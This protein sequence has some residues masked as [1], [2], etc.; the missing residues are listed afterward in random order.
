[1][2]W[3]MSVSKCAIVIHHGT[4]RT[5]VSRQIGAN[6]SDIHEVQ[7]LLE[8]AQR[9]RDAALWKLALAQTELATVRK[10]R[11]AARSLAAK[12]KAQIDDLNE[13][14]DDWKESYV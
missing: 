4:T 8:E 3:T 1:M 11:D 5:S 12:L 6:M 7:A 10:E 9:D 2:G 14:L 13:V